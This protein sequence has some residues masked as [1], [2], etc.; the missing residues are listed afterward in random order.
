MDT[1]NHTLTAWV[2]LLRG[3]LRLFAEG[4][5][6]NDDWV[7]I[8]QLFLEFGA[9]VQMDLSEHINDELYRANDPHDAIL[10]PEAVLRYILEDEVRFKVDF[11]TILEFCQAK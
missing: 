4:G 10:K 9:D 3:G 8:V 7:S 1:E 5:E 11:K 6:V 2:S